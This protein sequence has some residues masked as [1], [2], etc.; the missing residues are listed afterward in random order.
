[1]QIRSDSPEMKINSRDSILMQGILGE[2][3]P[4]LR[5]TQWTPPIIPS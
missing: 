1:M 2:N 3:E 4:Q 5:S